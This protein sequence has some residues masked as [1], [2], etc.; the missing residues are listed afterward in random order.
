MTVLLRHRLVLGCALVALLATG[1]GRTATKPAS[2]RRGARQL[3][4]PVEVMKVEA[5]PHEVVITAPGMVDAF[6]TIQITARV[7]GVVDRVRFVEGQEIK[8]GQVLAYI[9][10]R[11]YALNVSAGRAAVAKAEATVADVE[12]ALKRRENAVKNNPG[13]I[14]GEE[15]ETYQTKLRTARADADQAR[16]ALKLAQLNL[17]DSSVRSPAEGVIQ[18]RSVATGQMVQPGTVI[19]TVLRRD[20]MLL[21]FNATTAEAPR[22]KVGMPVEFTLKESQRAYTARITL[23]AAAA[24][25]ESRLVPVTAEVESHR[26]FWLRPGSFAVV[27]IKLVPRR[28]FPLIPQTAARPSDRG[29]LAYVVEKDVAHERVLKLGLHTAEG[30]VEVRDGL[31]AGETLV[32]KGLEA[33]ADGTRVRVV[34][35]AASQPAPTAGPGGAPAP[36]TARRGPAAPGT[37]PRHADAPGAARRGPAPGRGAGAP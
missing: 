2:G 16:E 5:K 25:P 17:S 4:F 23:V 12:A 27:R 7:A 26:K 35:P 14:P 34:D 10:S 22:L 30:W 20:P 32:T 28:E 21:R 18:T 36:G 11:R 24:D 33:L 31:Q 9:D 13:L 1:C 8:R 15:L 37:T 29:F 19:A 3:S 6:E